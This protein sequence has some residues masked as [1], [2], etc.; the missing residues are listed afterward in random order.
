MA[1]FIKHGEIGITWKY[2]S[3]SVNFVDLN[4]FG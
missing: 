2:R 1:C 4:T 3:S